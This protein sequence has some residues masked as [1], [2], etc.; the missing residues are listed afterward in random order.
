M[1]VKLERA[2]NTE[3]TEAKMSAMNPQS[4]ADQTTETKPEADRF[5]GLHLVPKKRGCGVLVRRRKLQLDR[6]YLAAMI[7]S[8]LVLIMAI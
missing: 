2:Q 8:A 1:R 3:P 5:R 6:L 7:A 4:H